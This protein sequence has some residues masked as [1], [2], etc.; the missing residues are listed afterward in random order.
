MPHWQFTPPPPGRDRHPRFFM[1]TLWIV[2]SP[3]TDA[4]R[5]DRYRRD[6]NGRP[7]TFSFVQSLERPRFAGGGRSPFGPMRAGRGLSPKAC[8][9]TDY[10]RSSRA[11]MPVWSLPSIACWL[12]LAATRAHHPSIH[13]LELPVHDPTHQRVVPCR[14]PPNRCAVWD[15][16][17]QRHL[18]PVVLHRD[19]AHHGVDDPRR[20][21]RTLCV[22][23]S[24]TI[25]WT[26]AGWVPWLEVRT[27]VVPRNPFC[28]RVG[29]RH[30]CPDG[31]HC[32]A[33]RSFGLDMHRQ[34]LQLRQQRGGDAP[35]LS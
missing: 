4:W 5:R 9:R 30:E 24:G 13:R 28:I 16:R 18:R 15:D 2:K 31:V 1:L 23:R 29:V 3:P 32:C 33:G 20:C 6:A 34:I 26:L 11:S 7:V 17:C 35:G 8:S 22:D 25:G 14:R 12:S 19:A 10:D 21:R 27:P